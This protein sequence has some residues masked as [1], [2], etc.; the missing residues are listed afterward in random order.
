M[1]FHLL[2]HYLDIIEIKRIIKK[3][4][5]FILLIELIEII[6]KEFHKYFYIFIYFSLS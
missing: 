3:I 2:N 6:N 4:F 1:E 5:T